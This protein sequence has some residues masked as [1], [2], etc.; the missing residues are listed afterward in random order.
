MTL[1]DI[2][3]VGLVKWPQCRIWGKTIS[4]EQALEIIRRTDKFFER[5]EY[6]GNDRDFRK[7]AMKIIRYPEMKEGASYQEFYKREEEFKKRWGVICTEYIINDWLA[8]SYI[9]GPHGWCHPDGTIAYR[10]NIGKWPEPEEVYKDLNTIAQNFPFLDFYCC[11]MN[12]EKD[13]DPDKCKLSFHVQDGEVE[14]LKPLPLKD[15]LPA[16]EI[17]DYGFFGFLTRSEHEIGLDQLRKWAEEVYAP[18]FI[19]K[20]LAR[21]AAQVANEDFNT[22]TVEI[23]SKKLAQKSEQARKLFEKA[24]QALDDYEQA[25]KEVANLLSE[26]F[27]KA[28]H[29]GFHNG[30]YCYVKNI[31]VFIY[32]SDKLIY[33]DAP[34]KHLLEERQKRNG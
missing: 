13:E 23:T 20:S 6:A 15:T 18:K 3:K 17:P 8:S 5:P 28:S 34:I 1:E 12:G 25:Q 21:T 30:D 31:G 22:S 19:V 10:D 33:L 26:E 29:E 16:L 14:I 24:L 11:I 2:K 4:E 32:N 7:E 9:G 27:E